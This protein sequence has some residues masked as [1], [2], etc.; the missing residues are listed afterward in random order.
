MAANKQGLQPDSLTPEPRS[1]Y[2]KKLC[3]ISVIK[4]E[5]SFTFF[6]VCMCVCARTLV[7]MCVSSTCLVF[8]FRVGNYKCFYA[9]ISIFNSESPN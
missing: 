3:Y 8:Y 7:H 1:I 6:R 2:D 4:A 9:Q 5:L